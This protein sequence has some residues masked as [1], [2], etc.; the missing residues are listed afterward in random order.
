M[1]YLVATP[2][3][4]LE[5]ITLRALRVLAEVDYI[6]CE[7][8]RKASFLLKHFGISKALVSFYEHNEGKKIPKIIEDLKQGK[9]IALISSA[10]TPG[11]SDP[12]F[13]LIRSCREKDLEITSLPGASSLINALAQS[14][15]PHDK[16]SFY[17]FFPRKKSAQK[18]ALE[19]I[20]ASNITSIFFESPYRIVKTLETI[21]SVLGKRKVSLAREMTKKFEEV[22]EDEIDK[23]IAHFKGKKPKGEFV[24]T[25]SKVKK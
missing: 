25:I 16:F 11:I 23:A 2:I 5:D 8:T 19:E 4:N 15:L 17:G 21:K 20:K 10:G 1:L 12:G 6:L 7:D 9:N 14:S 3:G 13:K 24:L 18:K 22:F